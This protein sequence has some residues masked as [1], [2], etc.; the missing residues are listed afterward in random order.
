MKNDLLLPNKC[1]KIGWVLLVP[2]VIL[3]IAIMMYDF[4]IPFLKMSQPA[5]KPG[6]FDIKDYD[7]S[8]EVAIF[9]VFAGLFMIAFS[10]EKRED[11]YV[12]SVRL[13]ALQI[14][15]YVNYIV[16]V[17]GLFSFYGFSFLMILYANLFTIL[18]I[19]IAVYSYKLHFRTG[20]KEEQA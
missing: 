10:K 19:F 2:S 1:R 8:N 12:A 13:K 17:V 11:E 20:L 14:S 5:S 16:L 18:I 7:M 4:S 9:L 15:V 6:S 3:L